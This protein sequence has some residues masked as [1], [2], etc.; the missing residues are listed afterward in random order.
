[1]PTLSPEQIAHARHVKKRYLLGLLLMVCANGFSAFTGA[2]HIRNPLVELAAALTAV[3]ALAYG[4]LMTWRLCRAL[5]VGVVASALTT[6][7]APLSFIIEAIVLLRLYGR[8]TG[9]GV[10][11]LMNDREPPKSLAA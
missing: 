1:M 7:L 3:A 9:L 8:R 4:M 10:G 6:L 11:F 5:S 2:F